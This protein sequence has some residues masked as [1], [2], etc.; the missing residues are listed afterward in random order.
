MALVFLI[1]A[2]STAI[3]A[4]EHELTDFADAQFPQLF[5]LRIQKSWHVNWKLGLLGNFVPLKKQ[6]I[7]DGLFFEESATWVFSS[8]LLVTC[9]CIYRI[10]WK[11]ISYAVL[12]TDNMQSMLCFMSLKRTK[13]QSSNNPELDSWADFILNYSQMF[14]LCSFHWMPLKQVTTATWSL[15]NGFCRIVCRFF[16]P[17]VFCHWRFLHCSDAKNINVAFSENTEDFG[18]W[19]LSLTQ[20]SLAMFPQ[21]GPA[22]CVPWEKGI[23]TAC[24]D[25]SKTVEWYIR[26][27]TVII[28]IYMY[29][30]VHYI[31]IHFFAKLIKINKLCMF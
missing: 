24:S 22:T 26:I 4:L 16:F 17:T 15:Y 6:E 11:V 2:F 3:M 29:T 23:K 25:R 5:V 27:Y 14:V 10:L 31:Y 12:S 8:D 9:F 7:W 19:L 30:N 20:M 1:F 13:L 18:T 21:V 28:Y